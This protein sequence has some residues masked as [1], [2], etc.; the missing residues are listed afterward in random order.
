MA[1]RTPEQFLNGLRDQREVYYRGQRVQVVTEHPELGVAARHAAIDYKMA[2]D[3]KYR[4]LALARDGNDVYSA[5]YRI[6]RDAKDLC[7]DPG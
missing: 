2:E 1:L 5:Y 7:R 3:P 6:P 4:D